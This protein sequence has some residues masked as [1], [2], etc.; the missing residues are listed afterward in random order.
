MLIIYLFNPFLPTRST[1]PLHNMLEETTLK[2]SPRELEFA[3]LFSS[4]PLSVSLLLFLLLALLQTQI[5]SNDLNISDI[6]PWTSFHPTTLSQHETQS[7]QVSASL[8]LL[9]ETLKSVCLDLQDCTNLSCSWDEGRPPST[10]LNSHLKGG[11][12]QQKRQ[13]LC[14]LNL[15]DA[16]CFQF[17]VIPP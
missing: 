12:F 13:S 15:G 14:P 8:V 7:P 5:C 4:P 3:I 10:S 1:V 9:T 17:G 11:P 2:C 6:S 16:T